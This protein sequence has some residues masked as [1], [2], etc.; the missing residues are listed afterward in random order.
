[1]YAAKNIDQRA[2]KKKKK[3][4]KQTK[5]KQ[6]TKKSKLLVNILMVFPSRSGRCV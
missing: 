3:I 4:S 6:K 5:T 2:N 1:M